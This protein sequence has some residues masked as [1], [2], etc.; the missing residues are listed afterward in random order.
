MTSCMHEPGVGSDLELIALARK[1][2]KQAF[3]TLIERHYHSCVNIATF[4]L[5]DRGA[6]QDEVQ[7][8]CWK[9]FEHLDQYQGT[10]EFSTWLVRIVVNQCLMLLRVKRR[11]QFLYI[12]AENLST[13]SSAPLQLPAAAADAEHDVVNRQLVEVLQRELRRIPALLR[14]VILLRDVEE[15]PMTD[16]AERLGITVAAAKS[17]LLRARLELRDRIAGHCGRN[18]HHMSAS[19]VQTLPAKSARHVV[20][21][22]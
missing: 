4:I 17:R 12:D 14:N 2:D 5:R 20:W 10:A 3:G 9:A 8:A 13:G 21:M 7:E 1:G 22:T 16:V 11:M 15:L 18:G 6:A 19:K